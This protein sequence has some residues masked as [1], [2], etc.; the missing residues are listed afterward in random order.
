M[1]TLTAP[2]RSWEPVLRHRSEA[3][4]PE[5]VARLERAGLSPEVVHHALRDA[6]DALYTAA[7]GGAHGWADRFGG[8][9]V[10]ALLAAEIS[11]LT[12]HLNSRA[13]SV[14]SMAVEDLL[15]DYSAV[16]VAAELGV[17]RQKVYEVARASGRPSHHMSHAP[18]RIRDLTA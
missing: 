16:T 15:E 10:A 13:S 5:V 2:M 7:Q 9:L 4:V 1:P 17:S 11:A 8:P 3:E 14:R 6:G 18:W 12:V